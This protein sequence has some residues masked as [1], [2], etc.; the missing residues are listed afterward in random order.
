MDL[1][2]TI[3]KAKEMF[4]ILNQYLNLKK[5]KILTDFKQFGGIKFLAS[6]KQ[7][8]FGGSCPEGVFNS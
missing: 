3:A 2:I 4:E 1:R 8:H 5:I 6:R 7:T